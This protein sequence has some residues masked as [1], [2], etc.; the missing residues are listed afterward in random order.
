M[1]EQG[2]TKTMPDAQRAIVKTCNLSGARAARCDT[3]REYALE[4]QRDCV[5][6]CNGDGDCAFSLSLDAFAQNVIEGRI[7]LLR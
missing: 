4:P 1:N 2:E 5:R 3:T 6:F 7:A